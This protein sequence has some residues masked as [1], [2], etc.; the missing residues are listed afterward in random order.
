M[1]HQM[2]LEKVRDVVERAAK[3]LCNCGACKDSKLR[4][5]LYDALNSATLNATP[6]V[7]RDAERYRWLSLSGNVELYVHNLPGVDNCKQIGEDGLNEAIDKMLL[8]DQATK[9]N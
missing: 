3:K 1:T 5:E 8:L 2:T 9:D 4:K 6:D 7:L